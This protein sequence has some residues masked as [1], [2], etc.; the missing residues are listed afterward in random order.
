MFNRSPEALG[1]T[2]LRLGIVSFAAFSLHAGAMQPLVTDDTGSQG[3]GGNQLEFSFNQERSAAEDGTLRTRSL[4]LVYTR[5]LSET[6]DVYAGVG[7]LRLRGS[8]T[9]KSGAGNPV[10]GAKWRF[11][12]NEA[13]KTSFAIKPELVFPVSASRE[14]AGLGVGKT[15]GSLTLI[16][17]QEL[18]FGA[19][20][21][22]AGV[23]RERYRDSTANADATTRRFS[24]APVWDVGAQ[25]KLA[26]D[27]GVE[28]ARAAASRVRTTFTELAA[29]Y[30][31]NKALDLALGL[32]EARD[33]D[34]NTTHSINAGV[35]WRFE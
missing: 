16:A 12:D 26:A 19:L 23:G 6:I 11:L 9:T 33:N 20:H 13:S 25:W 14:E 32:I 18:P 35:T 30:A 21:F 27:L 28:S 1:S 15:S 3:A 10:L 2:L 8:G 31:P 29:I 17:S 34:K 24:L 5:G 4:P 22:N 7:Y